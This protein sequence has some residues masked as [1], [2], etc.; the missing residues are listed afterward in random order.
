MLSSVSF[1][2]PLK[3]LRVWLN[4]SVSV[5]NMININNAFIRGLGK[6]KIKKFLSSL[7]FLKDLAY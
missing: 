4:F 6:V 2:T 5:S 3:F 1:P 7:P